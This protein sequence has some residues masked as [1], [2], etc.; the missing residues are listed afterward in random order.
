MFGVVAAICTCIT[1]NYD[2]AFFF[3][4]DADADADAVV[5]RF[6]FGVD[7]DAVVLRF[8]F[9]VDA[10]AV[11]L[12]FLP[13]LPSPPFFTVLAEAFA[14]LAFTLATLPFFIVFSLALAFFCCHS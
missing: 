4:V 10:D 7:V 3:G 11:V 13:L 2:F 6:F 9:G 1:S 8:F 14:S 5:L 12:C